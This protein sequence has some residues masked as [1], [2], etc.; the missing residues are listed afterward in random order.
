MKENTVQTYNDG[1]VVRMHNKR[2]VVKDYVNDKNG[3]AVIEITV[4]R[5][6]L[7]T[8]DMPLTRV[9]IVK[10]K[11]STTALRISKEAM[12]GLYVALEYYLTNQNKKL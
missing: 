3:G 7:P 5:R 1:V 9:Q 10:G 11:V 6:E 12:E 4:A 8:E 2:I